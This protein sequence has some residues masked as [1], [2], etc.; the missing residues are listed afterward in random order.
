MDTTKNPA[1]VALGRL[2]G[3]VKTAKGFAKMD[4]A[5]AAEY[6]RRGAIKRAENKKLLDKHKRLS[7]DET[8]SQIKT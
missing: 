4:P 3:K 6:G 8:S 1:A 2:G 7:E 5:M